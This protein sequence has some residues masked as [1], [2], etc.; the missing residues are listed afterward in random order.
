MKLSRRWRNLG[1]ASGAVTAVLFAAYDLYQ[2]AQA[3]AGDRFHNDFTFYYA[4]ARIGLAHGWPSISYLG[5]QQAEL[6]AIGS[7]IKIAQLARYISPP[8]VAW[9]ALPLTELPFTAAYWTWSALLVIAL[10]VTW[11]LASPGR[12]AWGLGPSRR[13]G[14]P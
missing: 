8:P 5:L 14:G 3:Y 1:I 13:A 2:W 12:G 7:G 9:S 10:V 4:A 11:R 6:D